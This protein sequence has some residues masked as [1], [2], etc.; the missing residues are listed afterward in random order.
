MQKFGSIFLNA[1]LK[2]KFCIMNIALKKV[3]FSLALY[4]H[5]QKF[6]Q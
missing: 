6:S 1:Y 2:F 5:R 4:T 3:R